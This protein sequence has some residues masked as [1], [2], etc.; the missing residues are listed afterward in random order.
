MLTITHCCSKQGSVTSHQWRLCRI[1]IL[2]PYPLD[3]QRNA[4]GRR[5][6]LQPLPEIPETS[7]MP[8]GEVAPLLK[9]LMGEYAATGL[10]PAY[11][12]KHPTP[13]PEDES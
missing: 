9:K 11:L 13:D 10:P 8:T 12:P 1:S 2:H 7:S 6:R 5:R 3:K 4:D